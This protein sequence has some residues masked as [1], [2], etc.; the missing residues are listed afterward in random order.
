MIIAGMYSFNNGQEIIG[1]NYAHELQEVKEVINLIDSES[2]RIKISKEKTMPGKLLYQPAKLNKLFQK[3]FTER[4]WQKYRIACD[5][6]NPIRLANRYSEEPS[7]GA[8]PLRPLFKIQLGLLYSQAYYTPEYQTRTRFSK[9][10]FRE[11]DFIKNEV[12][13]EVQFGKYAFMVYNVC[14]KMTIF[15]NLHAINVGIEIVPVKEFAEQ[16]S[17]GVSYFEQ[18]VWDL[19][20]RGVANID[21]PVP[22]LGVTKSS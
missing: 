12:G 8:V 14:A 2:C 20:H 11:M 7:T 19:E 1:N 4:Q 9:S 22:I 3:A 21:I 18:F 6:S 5:Y 16:M 15:R 17:T 13:V 10:A